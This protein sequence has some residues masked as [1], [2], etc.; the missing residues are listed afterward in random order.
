MINIKRRKSTASPSA[1]CAIF[2][3]IA[4]LALSVSPAA[5]NAASDKGFSD[6]PA[7]NSYYPYISYLATK[8]LVHGYPDGSFLPDASLTRAEVSAMMARAQG[9]GGQEILESS[10][11][12]VSPDHWACGVIEAAAQA[13]L[14]KGYPDGSFRPDDLLQGRRPA[15][16]SCV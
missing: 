9:L 13:G 12:D 15:L 2:L 1:V 16:C 4:V 11:N 10:F 5:V 3:I 6:V 8:G 14:L 7:E